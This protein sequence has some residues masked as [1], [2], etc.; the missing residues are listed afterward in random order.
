MSV[1]MKSN[2][3]KE[4]KIIIILA[5]Y[6]H[7]FDVVESGKDLYKNRTQPKNPYII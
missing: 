4:F 1:F 3:N 5:N 7:A 2:L 6:V